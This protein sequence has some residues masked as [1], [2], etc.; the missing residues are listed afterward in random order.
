MEKIFTN[1]NGTRNNG[2]NLSQHKFDYKYSEALITG[3]IA[4]SLR[5]KVLAFSIFLYYF[6][7]NGTLGL[8]SEKSYMVFRGMR[9]SDLILYALVGYTAFCF[10]EYQDLF[11]SKIFLMVKIFLLYLVLEFFISAIRYKFNIIEYFFRLKGVWSSFLIFPFM[12][13]IKRDGLVFL[14]KLIFP[15]AIVSNILYIMTALTG[16]LYLPDVTII[17][18]RLPGD[19]EVFRVFGGTFFG[20]LFL[21]GFIYYWMCRKFRWYQLFLV[22]FFSIPH[23]LAFGR[24]AWTNIVFTIFVIIFLQFLKKKNFRIIFRQGII[25]TLLAIALI[26]CFIKFVP[27]SDYYIDALGERILQGKDDVT[28]G[29]GTYGTRLDLQNG[30]LVNLWYNSNWFLGIGMHPMWVNR[31]ETR[32]EQ[33]YY[34]AFSDVAWPSVLAAYGLIGLGLAISIQFKYIK[35]AYK[36][37]KKIKENNIYTLILTIMFAKM[38]FDTFISYSFLFTS[39]SLWGLYLSLNF[40]FPAFIY[41]YEKHKTDEKNINEPNIILKDRYKHK[42]KYANNKSI[43]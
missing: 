3:S 36:L 9:L 30:S 20:E 23:I 29:E 21:F 16:N 33:V 4:I 26:I 12:L 34:G 39:I 19:M 18:Q 10:R 15:V 37:L 40:Y 5:T 8:F 6:I 28:Y 25:I 43:Q 17:L 2:N 35:T 42:Y 11:K 13:L 1:Y 24:G 31:P 7:E 22:I 32:E 41:L 14:A 38:V 27:R